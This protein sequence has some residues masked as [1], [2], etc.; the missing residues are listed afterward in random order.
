M[1]TVKTLLAMVVMVMTLAFTVTAS[2]QDKKASKEAEVKYAVASM[3]CGQCQKKIEAVIPYV[4]GVKDLKVDLPA[5]TVWVKYD[6][7][8]TTKEVLAQ[9]LKKIGF[10]AKEE[11]IE[12]K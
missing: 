12:K 7:T 9:E 11:A 2:A 1:K 5:K 6:N 10:E 4:K 8:K 3:D